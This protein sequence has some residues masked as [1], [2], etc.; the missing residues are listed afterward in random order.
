M[1]TDGASGGVLKEACVVDSSPEVGGA[2]AGSVVLKEESANADELRNFS[3]YVFCEV[4]LPDRFVLS[5]QFRE[6]A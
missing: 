4:Q 3:G 1:R 5:R 2:A 6:P